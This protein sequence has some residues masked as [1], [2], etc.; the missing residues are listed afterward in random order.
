MRQLSESRHVVA[1]SCVPRGPKF[2]HLHYLLGRQSQEMVCNPK[3]WIGVM[4]EMLQKPGL[5][6][7]HVT[8]ARGVEHHLS[9]HVEPFFLQSGIF[10]P[11]CVERVVNSTGISSWIV[12]WIFTVPCCPEGRQR[13]REIDMVVLTDVS[14][15]KGLSPE[16]RAAWLLPFV[17]CAAKEKDLLWRFSAYFSVLEGPRGSPRRTSST[18]P[19]HACKSGKS[20]AKKGPTHSEQKS[21]PWMP[22]RSRVLRYCMYSTTYITILWREEFREYVTSC[23]CP[24]CAPCVWSKLTEPTNCWDCWDWLLLILCYS[25]FPRRSSSE[26]G[27][28]ENCQI[29]VACGLFSMDHVLHDC[30]CGRRKLVDQCSAEGGDAMEAKQ[31]FLAAALNPS[32]WAAVLVADI[33]EQSCHTMSIGGGQAR[34]TLRKLWLAVNTTPL[35]IGIDA[36]S[37]NGDQAR[38]CLRLVAGRA[39]TYLPV[40]QSLHALQLFYCKSAQCDTLTITLALLTNTLRELLS[41][42]VVVLGNKAHETSASWNYTLWGYTPEMYWRNQ[43][44]QNR[45]QKGRER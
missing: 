29:S 33:A 35:F 5:G 25:S 6:T 40:S 15:Q 34:A 11:L 17:L 28:D 37:W 31:F 7:L 13:T 30:S 24:P 42:R 12:L 1:F 41:L 45:M 4:S 21:S 23:P 39:Q 19:C 22:W 18:K 32:P 9:E 36:D 26:Q 20:S 8:H 2:Q 10:V 14:R 27:M 38:R 44:S 43:L 16:S 3:V